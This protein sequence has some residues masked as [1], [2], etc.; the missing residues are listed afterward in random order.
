DPI[1]LSSMK[2][3]ITKSNDWRISPVLKKIQIFGYI[4]GIPT[5]INNNVLK[6]YSQGKKIE[7]S[8]TFSELNYWITE[9]FCIN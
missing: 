7:Q 2:E 6:Q 4:D 5:S 3:L 1:H 8:L 9:R